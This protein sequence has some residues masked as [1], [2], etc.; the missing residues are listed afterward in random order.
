MGR[1]LMAQ[2][3]A[4]RVSHVTS[5]NKP[6]KRV[7]RALLFSLVVLGGFALIG[8]A[9]VRAANQNWTGGGATSNW[10]DVGNWSGTPIPGS[11]SV[12][13]SPDVATFNALAGISGALVNVDSTTQ[14]IGGITFD[15]ASV[16]SYTIGTV[17]G[18]SLF[19]SSG[20]TIQV[21]NTVT[22]L[23]ETINAPLKLEGSYTFT[24]ASTA[25]TLNIGG[26]VAGAVAGAD[27]VTLNGA[28]NTTFSGGVVLGSATSLL[29][30]N[31]GTGTVT[32]SGSADNA[33][34][35]ISMNN[36]S[37]KIILGKTSNSGVHA[38]GGPG[39]TLTTGLIQ[40]G[41]SGGDQI[42]NNATA[43]I[44]G[45]T[46]DFNGMSESVA[47][48]A[49]TTT[50]GTVLNNGNG[51]SVLT[52]VSATSSYTGLIKDNAAGTGTVALTVAGA[53][54]TIS[55]GG[56]T[57]TGGT[58]VSSG[59]L[60]VS[61]GTT[62]GTTITSGPLGL[63][64]IALNGGTLADD[65]N[66]NRVLANNFNI[67]GSVA[68]SP[69]TNGFTWNGTG[70]TTPATVTINASNP[71]ITVNTNTLTINDAIVNGSGSSLVKA[72]TGKL[73]LL[74][75]S[76]YN[77]GTTLNS[78]S[79]LEVDSS[80]TVTTGT[81]TNGPIGTGTL[82]VSTAG[83]TFQS[84]IGGRT[85]ANSAV[86][87]ANLTLGGGVVF[88]GT[89]RSTPATVTLN[90]SPQITVAN[91]A[92]INDAIIGGNSITKVGGGN[93]VLSGGNTY[94]NTTISAG[95]V[96][97][98]NAAAIPG[99]TQNVTVNS[100]GI[101]A[102]GP[103]FGGLQANLLSRLVTSSAGTVALS[104]NTNANLD[105]NA[106]GLTAASLGA[107]GSIT[108]T[109]TLTPNGTTY[110]LGGGTGTL[111]LNANNALTGAG[112]GVTIGGG[113]TGG[114]VLLGG[115][116]N[117]TGATTVTSGTL[118][119]GSFAS[120]SPIGG[121]Q[122]NLGGGTFSIRTGLPV[123][124]TGYNQDVIYGLNEPGALNGSTAALDG[125]LTSNYVF[126]Q[127]GVPGNN[128]GG[129]PTTG[130]FTSLA[131]PNVTFALQPYAAN[132][133]LQLSGTTVATN[134][135]TLTLANPA[136]LNKLAFLV[137]GGGGAANFNFTLNF[138]DS[139]TTTVTGQ[140]A[141]DWF[142]G[143]NAAV[144]TL[145]RVTRAG[146]FDGAANVIGQQNPRMYEVDYTFSAGDAAK[147]LNSI[148]FDLTNGGATSPYLNVFGVSTVGSPVAI[149][150]GNAVN[151]TANSSID[152]E[153]TGGVTLG[154]LTMGAQTLT[155]TDAAST[156]TAY[157]LTLGT[158]TFSGNPTFSVN[159]NGTLTLGALNDGNAARTITSSGAG[160]L[161]LSAAATSL[162]NGTTV[163]VTAGTLNSN[164]ATA[165]GN[166]ANV[167]VS[168]AAT[169]NVNAS[170]TIGALNGPTAATITSGTTNIGGNTLTI[171][172]T[173]NLNSVAP[174]AIN[175]NGSGGIIKAGTGSVVLAGSNSY[176]SSTVNAGVLQ[177]N[178]AASIGASGASITVNSG[179]AVAAG[180]A[181]PTPL[182]TNLMNRIVNTSP[183][184]IALAT[185]SSE[186]FDWS[187][188]GLNLTGTSLGAVSSATYTGNF[189]PNNNTYRL[190]GGGGALTL[191]NTN[192]LTGAGNSLVVGGSGSGGSV[193]LTAPNNYGGGTTVSA[194]TLIIGSPS[195]GSSI[196]GGN[197]TL[198]GG[199][200]SLRTGLPIAMSTSTVNGSTGYNQDLIYGAT[201]AGPT[202]GST[203]ALD[204]NGTGNFVFFQAGVPGNLGG[205]LNATGTYLSLAN[206][207]AT[208]ALQP[209]QGN[210]TMRLTT[211]GTATGTLTLTNPTSLSKLAL[212]V[213]G[214]NGAIPFSF[215]FNFSDNSTTAVTG[216]TALDWFTGGA[217]AAVNSLS[218]VTRAG[219]FA[220]NGTN[221]NIYELDYTLSAGDAAKTLN[222]ITFTTTSANFLN[223]F[224]AS[225]LVT[226]TAFNYTNNVVVTAN[227]TIDVQDTGGVSFGTLS[228]GSNTLTVTNGLNTATAYSLSL[229]AVTLSGSPTFNVANSTGGGAGSLTLGSL[230]DGGT[231][232]TITKSGAGSLT[233]AS[234]ATSLVTGTQVNITAGTLFSNHATALGTTAQVT[235]NTGATLNLG[236][237][238]TVSA[239]SGN[240]SVNL[241]ANTLNVG[242]TDNLSSSFG[243]TLS[244][245]GTLNKAGN[246][247]FTLSGGSNSHG[248]TI[249]SS[250]VLVA[251]NSMSL[252]PADVT[253][254][255]GT[256]RPMAF[257]ILGG[258]GGNGTGWQVNQAGAYTAP[259]FPS[260]NVLELT[261]NGGSQ[262][263]SAFNL[264]PVT[265]AGPAGGFTASFTYTPSGSRAADGVAFIIQNDTRGATALG[266]GGGGF[267]FQGITPSEAVE[268]N[269]YTGAA[270]GIGTSLGVNGSIPTNAPATP[271]SLASG[272]PINVTVVYDPTAN[273]ITETMV[274]GI[275]AATKSITY[276]NV[277][278][279]ATVG[280]NTAYVGFSGATGGAVS[281]Q[282]ISNFVYNYV[283]G[284]T[285]NYANNLVLNGATTSTIDV[286]A[287]ASFSTVTMGNLTVN[288]GGASQLNVT[289]TTA[290]ANQAYGLTLGSVTLNS[291]I[292]FNVAK[293]GTGNGTL[294]LGAL[295]DNGASLNITARG[296]GI[297]ALNASGSLGS[298]TVVNAGPASGGPDGGNLRVG[299]LAGSATGSA[300][301]N[302]RNGG[303]LGVS[304]G[305]PSG[306]INGPVTVAT[307]GSLVAT[308]G[309]QLLATGGLSLQGGT[310]TN[311][312]LGSPSNGTSSALISTSGGLSATSLSITGAHTLTIDPS[313]LFPLQG[314]T[315]DLFDYTGN[316]LTSTSPTGTTLNFTN[317]GAGA[318]MTISPTSTNVFT[319]L[320]SNN[321][322]QNQ[323]D[324]IATPVRLIWT[325]QQNGNGSTL[326]NWTTTATD[327]NWANSVNNSAVAFVNNSPVR[328][329]DTNPITLALVPNTAGIATITIQPA[330]VQ[331][332]L[333]EFDNAGASAGGVDYVIS[334]GPIADSAS[335][336]ALS[337]VGANFSGGSVTLKSS[338]SFSGPVAIGLGSLTVTNT[339]ATASTALGNSSGVTVAAT[340]AALNLQSPTG[341]S[342]AFG[343]KQG[344]SGTVA[345]TLNGTGLGVNP[346]ALVNVSGNNTYS[347]PITIGSSGAATVASAAANSGDDLTLSGGVSLGAGTLSVIGFQ[348]LTIATV[349]ISDAG[350]S[351][352][353]SI[354]M[355]G[356]GSLNLSAP[357][358]YFGATSINS[359]S[360]VLKNAT[361][362]GNSSGVNV[363]ASSSLVLSST[364][365]NSVIYGTTAGGT[366]RVGVTLNGADAGS[367]ASTFNSATGVN[368]Y[369][370]SVTI[371]GGYFGTLSATST[372]NGDQFSLSGGVTV[373]SFS[374]LNVAGPGV[375]NI[376][377]G[378]AGSGTITMNAGGTLRISGGGVFNGTA[379]LN[380]GTTVLAAPTALGSGTAVLNTGVLRLQ[381]PSAS[382][383]GFGGTSS[384]TAGGGTPWVVNN[385]LIAS[386]PI[387]NNVLTLTDGIG[388][389]A[390][391]A[392]YNTPQP[393]AVGNSGFIASFTYKV[394][395]P[396]GADGAAFVISRDTRGTAALGGTGGQLGYSGV[397]PSVGEEINIYSGHT[398]GTNL[399]VNGNTSTYHATGAVDFSS[400]DP[401]NVVLS[402]NPATSTVTEIDFDTVTNA[403]YTTTYSQNFAG[404]GSSTAYIGFT[405][406]TGG[407][408]STQTI[409]NFT[410]A[411]GGGTSFSN[412]VV[413]TAGTASTID[414][415]A[416]ASF[417]T[418]SMGTL[419]V[420]SGSDSTLN[421][422]A[423]TAPANQ[424][425]TLGLGATTLNANLVVNVANNTNGGG[426]GSGTLR[427]GPVGDSGAGYGI[428]KNGAGTLL[429]SAAGA[430]SGNT[431]ANQGNVAITH[432]AV[433]GGNPLGTSTVHMT[434]GV[435]TLLAPPAGVISTALSATGYNQDVVWGQ[436]EASPTPGVG[437][438]TAYDGTNAATSWVLYEAGVPNSPGGGLPNSRTFTSAANS[439]IT[440]SLQP[441]A[442]NNS[443]QLSGTTTQANGTLSLSAPSK[444]TTL[445]LLGSTGSGAATFNFVLHF[446]DGSMTT[447]TGNSLA[448]WFG[449]SP[450]AIGA[451]GRVQ[452][453]GTFDTG[454]NAIAAGNPRLYEL[455]YNLSAADQL[456]VLN[457]ID[458]SLTNGST[459]GGGPFLNIMAVDGGV[460]SAG[461][462][463]QALNN[464]VVVTSDATVD[465]QN[466]GTTTFG[467]LSIGSNTLALTNSVAPSSTYGV[468]FGATTLSGSPNFNVVTSGGTITLGPVGGNP[469]NGITA[470]GVGT[471]V[472]G[473]ANTYDGNT[474][475]TGGTLK[476]ADGSAN[477][478]PNSPLISVGAGATL[479]VT[480]LQNG[481]IV[482]GAV[483]PQTL[484]GTG[485]TVTGGVV[486]STGSTIAG[487]SGQTLT[488]SNGLTLENNS[489]SSFALGTPNGSGNPLTALVN[490]AGGDFSIAPGDVN[491]V[492]L[493]GAA[494]AGTYEL[495]AFTSGSP[496][497][498][499]FTI[500]T[501]TAGSF[502]Y[503]FS[504]TGSEV[505][506]LVVAPSTSAAWNYKNAGSSDGLYSEVAKWNPTQ[507]P[508][509]PGSTATFGNGVTT[510]IDVPAATVTV[511][512]AY[513]VGSLV[514][515]NTHGTKYILGNDGVGSHR[516]TLDNNGLGASVN[517]TANA[518]QEIHT[519]LVLAD[520]TTFNVAS[521]SSMLVTVGSISQSGSHSLT[522]T[523]GG[524]LTIDTPSNYSGGTTVTSGTLATTATGAIGNGPLTVSTG[525]GA[526]SAANLGSSQTVSSLTGTVSGGGSATVKVAQGTT[527]TDNQSSG[528][529][530]SGAVRL[531][532]GAAPH[533][534]GTLT[535]SGNGT[536]E[537]QGA[538]HFD[539]HSNVNVT[540]GTLKFNVTGG[541]PFVGTGVLATV[542]NSAVLELA[543]SVSALDPVVPVKG[544]ADV[545]N[546]SNAVA[547][548][549]VTGT[550]QQVGGIDGS[551]KTQVDPG[552]G[553]TAN[554]IVQSALVIGGNSAVV[555]IAASDQNGNAL[556]ESGNLA[557]AGSLRSNATL[558]GG[559]ISTASLLGAGSSGTAVG[560]LGRLATLNIAGSTAAVPEPSTAVLLLLGAA[561]GLGVAFRRRKV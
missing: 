13:N 49:S 55:N 269:I 496:T 249:V 109:G 21:T 78:A 532:A 69:G 438:T 85:V 183:G 309:S 325:G 232:R 333:I 201:E 113:G 302:V 47:G 35:S 291:D 207:L 191:P 270:G 2:P 500:G 172:S 118:A 223:V 545:L 459:T 104:T 469:G 56:N 282:T 464:N 531:D 65:A 388:N 61:A 248:S 370:G 57:Y 382:I 423:S 125:T 243:G 224:G 301:V 117:F 142:G 530:Y 122:L 287:S 293:N 314:G 4:K 402:Y 461:G 202:P 162:I 468:T 376:A 64:T 58:T 448:D 136:S 549:H 252:G 197:L 106:A 393:Y 240:G 304:A 498:N 284:L 373:P 229:G 54:Q 318:S 295:N 306:T 550:N 98:N 81:L 254:A 12:V 5:I 534:G 151:L 108:Y 100:G 400:G 342:V 133:V 11:T 300:I 411:V 443:L 414:V 149:N 92:F 143:A 403:T 454:T 449:G 187:S 311:L 372:A 32:F 45:G 87:G 179:G 525:G 167:A 351:T 48:L 205:G 547:G 116:N 24:N 369:T 276:N 146:A 46:F 209:Y 283:G 215:T 156:A 241:N 384:S 59:T 310:S 329:Q 551:G 501:N 129:L 430:Y 292:T 437:T 420:S 102:G 166:L 160:T 324:L 359:G 397:T 159:T 219:A 7:G 194:G 328:L 488:I 559:S 279:T 135:G 111:A 245:A 236:A 440:F 70:L 528:T 299:N 235:V 485:G 493:S 541:A 460:L 184:T 463:D 110:R 200:V 447:V 265:I 330:G 114:T 556:A 43:T 394:G 264:T 398:V 221:P 476:L 514:F 213:T 303:S 517:V 152:V 238:Q 123:A 132:N 519:N 86:F 348:N 255:G 418:L 289:A 203:N 105:F 379:N 237:S 161:T 538:P 377:S 19:L 497:A 53:L 60:T 536:L 44:N 560:G 452:T 290:P 539:D 518:P 481:T 38:V 228:I 233:L 73:T 250:G 121:G 354:V 34:I 361:A 512:G 412:S 242:S 208:V 93:L 352:P 89:N 486:V 404:L 206:P 63:G 119:V 99:V 124:T 128:G 378:I 288:S 554:H 506:L 112:N 410:Y 272:D 6:A 95:V 107:L 271:V 457:S 357:S 340:G 230:N 305:A 263:R 522:L 552:S 103:A 298:G 413:T 258:F 455:D 480:G 218:R 439:N 260:P 267:G 227:S 101:V 145:G 326:S 432:T 14:N 134:E 138:S 131:N 91:S 526:V 471:V 424:S 251:A 71:T 349:G 425:Y 77:G 492:D 137:D 313:S 537:I 163:N 561:A 158:A 470:S 429:L 477:N 182:A 9:E 383:T 90:T 97:F 356:T 164:N 154:N 510:T 533:G 30:T 399:V 487:A 409:S 139:T 337:L 147:T 84:D 72:G 456:K 521:G 380:S 196:G 520:N 441:Y 246:G 27:T 281:T 268:L 16:D 508:N 20:G 67:G 37:G 350:V 323:I 277:N 387:T 199:T 332:A 516:I 68:V 322:A 465:S 144:N 366:A 392:W 428:T 407:V 395:A 210:N 436:S 266:T 296:A 433:A 499:Q 211:T 434:G 462:A 523:G 474:L 155:V 527:L 23:T 94:S 62:T 220:N 75:V 347:G 29:V 371:G 222:S 195:N 345:L 386:N 39:L 274:D 18:N 375:V 503:S 247:T 483:T 178:S 177:F 26:A 175:G 558:P 491:I 446:G 365:G 120:G 22:A 321:S 278:L 256:L 308:S 529:V 466:A 190:G 358:T 174:G 542:S 259:N 338:N 79:V 80:S 216:Q 405:G 364:S 307:G 226:P 472:L 176:G 339:T 15:T 234:A 417:S 262:A 83:A 415:G 389:E 41:G 544:R 153:N 204:G 344:G 189:T 535:K 169:F 52:V 275:T 513:T 212:F 343:G 504:V 42:A 126:Y 555:T 467:T 511:D 165:L 362:L 261:D 363:S 225:N 231:P 515:N 3:A 421:V 181:F 543:G 419:T 280:G 427:L 453:G 51:S 33:N 335:P 406:G 426:L 416:N 186:A 458:F 96:Q 490:V 25:T 505:D 540:G 28:G 130:S 385:T 214:G 82:T 346:A 319:F 336:T 450:T 444:V 66:V 396:G 495:F 286:G 391:T 141:A 239:L 253:L 157:S 482:L 150:Y 334:G 180:P 50:A 367:G 353:G 115:T 40:L 185:N 390:R 168:S 374:T 316:S 297:V 557:V 524:S 381:A 188:G 422:T 273:T 502:S 478:V 170:Q 489:H 192:A 294:T 320:L 317:S 546:N 36:A 244:G 331:P 76:T 31:T 173:N 507:V 509:T 140:T 479:D 198:S 148:T 217:T 10:S 360:V 408:A 74:G 341:A 8:P 1:F 193:I 435:L 127:A 484:G 355:N 553:L 431:V 88:D 401:I 368:T 475:V 473:A 494:Q 312:I 442:G 445:N 451:L 285:P 257:G 17:G 315:Y 548:L 327:K 171:G